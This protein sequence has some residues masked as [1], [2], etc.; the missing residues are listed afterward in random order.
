MRRLTDKEKEEIRQKRAEG[1]TVMALAVEYDTSLS[2]VTRIINERY[3]EN[4]R[5]QQNAR[6]HR[7]REE[8]LRMRKELEEIHGR[9]TE[10][11]V[12]R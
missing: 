10:G 7:Q 5:K 9:G 1:M 8:F 12:R 11:E 6:Y 4:I 2:T 3:A